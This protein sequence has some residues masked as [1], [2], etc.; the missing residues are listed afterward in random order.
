MIQAT[1]EA[2]AAHEPVLRKV[3]LTLGAAL[4]F[5]MLAALA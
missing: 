2:Q 1:F 4:A 5:A 3:L